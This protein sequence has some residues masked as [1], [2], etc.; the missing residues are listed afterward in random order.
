[1][2]K[3]RALIY[4]CHSAITVSVGFGKCPWVS[5]LNRRENIS[6]SLLERGGSSICGEGVGLILLKKL[7]QVTRKC[8]AK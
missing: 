4:A 1:M 8:G 3:G 2:M 7:R 5:C 6:F